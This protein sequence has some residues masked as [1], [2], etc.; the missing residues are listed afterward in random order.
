LL[1]TSPQWLTRALR[2][3]AAAA[4]SATV[5]FLRLLIDWVSTKAGLYRQLHESSVFQL[6]ADDQTG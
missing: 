1:P 5:A 6:A 2:A 4:R 3:M